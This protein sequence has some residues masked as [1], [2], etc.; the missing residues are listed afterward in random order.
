MKKIFT[1]L[2]LISISFIYAQDKTYV[3]TATADNTNNDITIINHPDLN[4]NPNA[5]IVYSHVWNP[6]GG[7][8]SF[9]DNFT[10]L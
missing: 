9:N 2:L 1:L 3:H 4:G 10:T 7:P 8:S 5:G 6:N